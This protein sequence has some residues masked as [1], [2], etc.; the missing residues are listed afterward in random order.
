M[1]EHGMDGLIVTDAINYYYFSGHRNPS[2][3]KSRPCT[4]VLPLEGDPAIISW[5]GPEMFARVYNRP[6]PS[7]VEDK[8][9]YPEVPFNR[10]DR[11]DWGIRDALVDRGLSEGR[12]GIELGRETWLGISVNDLELL[13]EELPKATFVES[14]PVVW[15]CRMIKSE[16]EIAC[17]AKAC[18]IGGIAWKQC[19]EELRPGITMEEIRTRILHLYLDGGADLTSEPPMAL[20]GTGPGGAFQKGDVLY[21]DG[22]PSCMGYRMD[23]TRRAVF[24]P[25][26]ERQIAEHNGMWEILF[27]VM[28]RMKPGVAVSEIFEYSQSL[29]AKT[30]WH[31]YSDHPAKRIG[32]GIGL[33][34]EPPSMNAFDDHL[35]EVGMILTPEPKIESPDGLVNPEEHIVMREHGV[36]ILSKIPDWPLYVVE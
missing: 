7:W 2:W 20:G 3:M 4:F 31:N 28:D 32:H 13:R 12:L 35:L 6:F 29:M 34:S 11:V 10:D 18:E 25:P 23:F 14:G 9:I 33:E 16:W 21:L 26:S 17:S 5:S 8:R 1:R 15:G 19:I 27:K 36:E 30:G 24:G 22:G